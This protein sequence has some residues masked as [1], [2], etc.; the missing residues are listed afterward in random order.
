MV[1]IQFEAAD[2]KNRLHHLGN[3]HKATKGEWH[4]TVGLGIKCVNQVQD[5]ETIRQF[6]ANK[7]FGTR[8]H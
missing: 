5:V 2:V 3:D 4:T 1:E 8:C 7:T 6:P